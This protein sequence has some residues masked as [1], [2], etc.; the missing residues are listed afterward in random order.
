MAQDKLV[1]K[2]LHH[3]CGWL[4]SEP[5]LTSQKIVLIARQIESVMSEAEIID[6]E[7]TG[8]IQQLIHY[9]CSLKISV[10]EADKMAAKGM[11]FIHLWS[12]EYLRIC[13]IK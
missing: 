8:L 7:T 6:Q 5:E 2:W 1:E 13:L 9:L 11:V 4:V 12:K 10:E 3:T